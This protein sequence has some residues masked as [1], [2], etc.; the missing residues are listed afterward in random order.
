MECLQ[1]K[2]WIE[3]CTNHKNINIF[4]LYSTTNP[5]SHTNLSLAHKR[6]V[7]YRIPGNAQ[8][9]ISY[10]IG[11][12]FARWVFSRQHGERKTQRYTPMERCRRFCFLKP[13]FLCC[14]GLRCFGDIR[15]GNS[16]QGVLV[17]FNSVIYGTRFR[18]L[19][20]VSGTV[21]ARQRE[22]SY[23]LSKTLKLRGFTHCTRLPAQY[24]PVNEKHRIIWAK[25]WNQFATPHL[26]QP[27]LSTGYTRGYYT[28]TGRILG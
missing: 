14:V 5:A 8:D 6:R 21:Y 7:Y 22:T 2:F 20:T 4:Q 28:H 3:V 16:P 12:N 13:P 19:Y 1:H 15:L 17:S 18:A 23:N 9:N 27:W 24:M 26:E 10:P 25:R 11:M